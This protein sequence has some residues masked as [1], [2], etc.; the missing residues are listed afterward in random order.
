MAKK[1]QERKQFNGVI[2]VTGEHD[3]GKTTFALECGASPDKILFIDDDLKGAATVSDLKEAGIHIGRYVNLVD[4]CSGLTEYDMHVKVMESLIRGIKPGEFDAIIWD[5]W[6][7][8]SD[9][10]Y[11]Y[12]KRHPGEFRENWAP[13]GSIKG[14]Q[15][16]K[17]A[18]RYEARIINYMATLAPTII[19]ITHLKQMYLSQA[20]VPGKQVPASSNALDRTMRMRLWLRLNPKGRPVPMALVLKR[21]DKKELVDDQLRTVN[22]LPR[23][24]IPAEDEHSLWDTIYRYWENPMGDREPEDDE[25]PDEY[26]LSLLSGTLTKE[27]THTLTMLAES[28]LMNRDDDDLG[29]GDLSAEQVADIVAKK[30]EGLPVPAIAS[31]VG[32]T[33]SQVQEVIGRLDSGEI[34]FRK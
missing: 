5:T 15:M 31:Q 19:L 32:V 7:Q 29:P 13:M 28:G 21:L 12:V 11:S 20:P 10:T 26:E 33:P 9:T 27:Q 6:T 2:Q 1:R 3:V 23:R 30:Q 25:I 8:F 34:D 16:W 22:V 18:R 17:E 14:P 4:F 24:L